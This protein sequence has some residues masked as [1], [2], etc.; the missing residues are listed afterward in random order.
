MKYLCYAIVISLLAV[1]CI[2]QETPRGEFGMGFSFAR[3]HMNDRTNISTLPGFQFD[4]THNLN[5]WFG[6]TGEFTGHY[7]CLAGCWW[8]A[9]VAR[10][11]AYV[12]AAGPRFAARNNSPM[13]PWAHV[14]AGVANVN[15]SSDLVSTKDSTT[16][17]ALVT[18]GGLDYRIGN[19]AVRVIQVDLLRHRAGTQMRN[20]L[21]FGFGVSIG[22]GDLERRRK[23]N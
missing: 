3:T 16:S 14:L 23:R 2:A 6:L 17:W 8:D 7:H 20:D 15:T 18:G 9:S 12:F 13:T 10:E 1:G 5:K 22:F 21:R 4:Y 19:V 11:K